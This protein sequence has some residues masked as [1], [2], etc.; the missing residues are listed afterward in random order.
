MKV[1]PDADDLEDAVH[2]GRVDAVEV[3]RVRVRAAVRELH[4]Q[5]VV[6]G[7]ADDGARARAVVRP[8]GEGD[9]LRHLDLLST[10]TSSYSRTRPGW[11]GSAGG[12]MSSASRSFGPA[13]RR[14]LGADHR[15]VAERGVVVAFVAREVLAAP[16]GRRP[17]ADP[18]ERA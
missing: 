8:G 10:A 6:L 11:C 1:S 3:D 18:A 2:V 7:R 15:R 5:K 16:V 12:G 14:D 17:A 9:A 4:A 13:G